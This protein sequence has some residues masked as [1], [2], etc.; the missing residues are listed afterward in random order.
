MRHAKMN[1][2]SEM[3]PYYNAPVGR[4]A[5]IEVPRM[6]F[7]MLD[8]KGDPA[9]AAFQEAVQTMYPLAYTIKFKVKRELG[10]DFQVM[11]LEG[12]W[13]MKGGGFDLKRR[14]EWLWT[15]MMMQ[16]D[17]VTKELF[18]EGV[19]E[20]REKKGLPGVED[21]RLE[22]FAEGLCVQTTHVGPY[23]TE[24]TTMAMM[25]EFISE[26][27]YKMTG[28]HHEIYMGD[29]RRSAPSKLRT[30]LRHPVIRK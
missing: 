8:G 13:W 20:V 1:L 2:K 22:K 26:N 29:P 27:G 5:V 3:A 21:A 6:K 28:K 15:I 7:I 19:G 25:S 17:L 4:V 14:D 23:S 16:P 9:K 10:K 12:L 30:V 11:P 24:P 18:S